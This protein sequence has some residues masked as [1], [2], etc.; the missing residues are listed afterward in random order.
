MNTLLTIVVFALKFLIL[1]F[2]QMGLIKNR[3]FLSIQCSSLDFLLRFCLIM[4]QWLTT[5]V[6]IERAHTI[7]KGIAFNKEKTRL[8]AKLVIFGLFLISI[9]TSI[10]DP[11]HRELFDEDL[12]EEKRIWCIVKY[13]STFR[14]INLIITAFHIITPFIINFISAIIIITVSAHQRTVI[15]RKQT[16]KKNFTEQFQQH[17]NLLI[18]PIVLIILGVPRLII[19]FASGCM[20]SASDSWLFLLGYYISFKS[21]VLAY[22]D[23]RHYF[24]I[25]VNSDDQLVEFDLQCLQHV[26]HVLKLMYNHRF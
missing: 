5:C 19:S 17:K 23:A 8:I 15:Q 6:A 9:V 11:I 4:D 26:L 16:Y 12:D 3:L 1:L 21:I 22:E 20:E 25:V 2:S 10:H 7:I 13:S 18:G 14:T 24:E